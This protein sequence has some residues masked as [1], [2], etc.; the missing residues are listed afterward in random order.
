MRSIS[1]SDK[2]PVR[3]AHF[4]GS[5]VVVTID[6]KHVKRLRIDDYTFFEEKAVDNGILLKVRKLAVPL[7]E[8]H[9]KG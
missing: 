6:P 3:Q 8:E 5:S 2:H 1:Q 7:K 4:A 9:E